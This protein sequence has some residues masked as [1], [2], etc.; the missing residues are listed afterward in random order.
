MN[1]N[2]D[3]GFYHIGKDIDTYINAWCFVVWSKRGPGK[4]YSGLWYPYRNNF[5]IVYMKRTNED[6]ELI[7]SS[8]ADLSFDPSPY[9]PL[10]RDK[11]INVQPK[12]ITKGVAGFWDFK[13]GSFTGL[14]RSYVISMNAVKR[15]KGLELS[16]C[17]WLLFDEFIPQIGERINR[18]EG[19][20][21]LD[22]YMTMSRDRE[23]RG[24][25]PLKL[26]LFANAEEISTPITN[27][28]EIVDSMSEL[29]ASGKSHLYIEDRGILLH[30]ITND[31]IPTQDVE[32]TGIYKA[33]GQTS[34]GRKAF[35]GEFSNNDFSNVMN[36]SLKGFRPLIKL[37]Y[38]EYE[39]FIYVNQNTGMYYMTTSPSKTI[40]TY[41]LNLENEQK[42]F[43]LNHGM[44]LRLECI[45][46]RFKFKKYT[47]YDLIMNYKKFFKI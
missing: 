1:E 15:V 41:D 21:L 14:P 16:M 46:G 4:T 22:F 2:Y 37:H 8:D 39:Y 29:N 30:H 5:P 35:E 3:D 36:M 11:D 17:D 33:M 7:C 47:M 19:E 20:L 25:A 27:T 18:R 26:I 42:F 13:D 34:W 12:V 45:N 38:K 23:K 31:E 28:L 44:K 43:W 6:V 10:N 24:K 9:A 32:K 40:F